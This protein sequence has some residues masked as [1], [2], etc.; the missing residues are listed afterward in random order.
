[1]GKP[2]RYAASVATWRPRARATATDSLTGPEP[3]S[4]N[5]ILPFRGSRHRPSPRTCRTPPLTVAA[6]PKSGKT[7]H[8]TCRVRPCKRQKPSRPVAS[9]WSATRQSPANCLRHRISFACTHRVEGNNGRALSGRASTNR[10]PSKPPHNCTTARGLLPGRL[11]QRFARARPA[12]P[13]TLRFSEVKYYKRLG[14]ERVAQLM[15]I[16]EDADCAYK[17]TSAASTRIHRS[18]LPGRAPRAD[19]TVPSVS[20][21]RANFLDF[22]P[23][24]KSTHA[25]TLLKASVQLSDTKVDEI[26]RAV[27]KVKTKDC[28]KAMRYMHGDAFVDGRTLFTFPQQSSRSGSDATEGRAPSRG[29][30]SYRAIKWHAFKTQR[31]RHGEDDKILDFCYLEY[32]G[33]KKPHPGSNVVGFCVQESISRDR[34]VPT[35]ENFGIA[36]GYLSRMG[37]IVSKTHQPN[38]FKVTSICQIDGDLNPIQLSALSA[39][40]TGDEPASSTSNDTESYI[41]GLR[42]PQHNSYED[43]IFQMRESRDRDR[44]Q[45]DLAMEVLEASSETELKPVY[46]QRKVNVSPQLRARDKMQALTDV[47]TH[48]R[49]VRDTINLTMSE[50]AYGER[51]DADSDEIEE[52]N[53]MYSEITSIRDALES[54]VSNFDAALANATNAAPAMYYSGP[55]DRSQDS[56][57]DGGS[58]H[59]TAMSAEQFNS[60]ARITFAAARATRQAGQAFLSTFSDAGDRH[61]ATNGHNNQ[62]EHDHDGVS[63]SSAS[64]ASYPT[65]YDSDDDSS[66]QS[67][68]PYSASNYEKLMAT[69]QPEH[70]GSEHEDDDDDDAQSHNFADSVRRATEIHEL[71]KKIRDL[72]RSLEDAQRKLSV[73]DSDEPEPEARSRQRLEAARDRSAQMEIESVFEIFGERGDE[74]SSILGDASS[75]VSSGPRAMSL[76]SDAIGSRGLTTQELV[77]ELR[78]VMASSETPVRASGGSRKSVSRPPTPPLPPTVM[79]APISPP[80]PPPPPMSPPK[81]HVSPDYRMRHSFNKSTKPNGD[82]NSSNGSTKKAPGLNRPSAS[83]TEGSYLQALGTTGGTRYGGDDDYASSS[84]DEESFDDSSDDLSM[85]SSDGLR[86]PQFKKYQGP[87]A[88][89]V[90][91]DLSALLKKRK[92]AEAGASPPINPAD[93]PS[94]PLTPAPAVNRDE[95]DELRELMAG[96]VRPRSSSLP[97]QSS[98]MGGASSGEPQDYDKPSW[99]DDAPDRIPTAHQ[100]EEA[101]REIRACL[102]SCRCECPSDTERARKLTS[103]FKVLRSL[104]REGVRSKFRTL[105]HDDIRYSKMLKATPS[106]IKLLKLAG[107]VSLQQK[108]TMRRVDQ[109]YLALFLRELEQELHSSTVA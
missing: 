10:A 23:A 104:H 102:A 98:Q 79:K 57:R 103:I 106:I 21:Q 82:L 62:E 64:V 39:T 67:P 47:V 105:Q 43:M 70:D 100:I 16:I 80:P 65:V 15:R 40:G 55:S 38:T 28:R 26:L 8:L 44:R 97:F 78:G 92:T 24:S 60:V 3:T 20:C 2:Q 27:S 68:D 96:L 87:D 6:T 1:M 77:S 76:P 108:L 18:R 71:E 99:S 66:A 36:R 11:P 81:K 19:A 73:I 93:S 89:Y 29:S 72:Q 5:G 14:K 101:V 95:R 86:E 4:A 31:P 48:I 94:S 56:Q 35:L 12:P 34:E 50:A 85:L 32:A 88:F 25:S 69:Y 90:E 84:S 59:G 58:D 52:F 22:Q 61:E 49:E 91:E 42:S 83:P 9:Q 109:D 51:Q 63:A 53:D 30:Y 46:P 7:L 13:L 75:S 41:R 54:S 37:I 74:K 17:W 45:S 107:Y 33:K